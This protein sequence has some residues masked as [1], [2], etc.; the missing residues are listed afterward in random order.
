MLK[1]L[2]YETLKNTGKMIMTMKLIYRVVF[3]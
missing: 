1:D 2:I 3:A